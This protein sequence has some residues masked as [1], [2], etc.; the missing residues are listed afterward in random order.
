[1]RDGVIYILCG[2][3]WIELSIRENGLLRAGKGKEAVDENSTQSFQ[4]HFSTKKK[5]KE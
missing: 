3:T 2:Y 1:M 4:L 5:R